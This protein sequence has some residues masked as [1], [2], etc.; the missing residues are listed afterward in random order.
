MNPSQQPDLYERLN[1]SSDAGT[2]DI[3]RAFGKTTNRW[4]PNITHKLGGSRE[5]Y[6][7]EDEDYRR[8]Y[9]ALDEAFQTL[10]NP[11]RRALYDRERGSVA[12]VNGQ[13]QGNYAQKLDELLK[14]GKFELAFNLAQ[15]YGDK[16]GLIR[17]L[18]AIELGLSYAY[19]ETNAMRFTEI[20]GRIIEEA[21][22]FDQ[23]LAM[24]ASLFN[25]T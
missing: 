20:K 19:G 7:Q 2:L 25:Q 3:V 12:P 8:E 18:A 6:V 21:K 22:D 9:L 24:L 5:K 11:Y 13:I 1:V 16:K 23:V 4:H 14:R 17:V 10:V 15:M